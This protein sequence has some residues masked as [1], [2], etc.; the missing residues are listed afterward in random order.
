[1]V[2]TTLATLVALLVAAPVLAAEVTAPK[3]DTYALAGLQVVTYC[4]AETDIPGPC[5]ATSGSTTGTAV[6]RTK[7]TYHLFDGSKS[8]AATFTCHVYQSAG[9][10][11]AADKQLVGTHALDETHKTLE[12]HGVLWP[13]WVE[14]SAASGSVTVVGGHRD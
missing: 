4:D 8:A 5:E 3:N 6:M 13:H 7:A 2:R 9:G 11:D 10:Y 12:V 1:M 14:C